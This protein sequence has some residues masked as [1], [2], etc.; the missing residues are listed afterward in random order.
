[1]SLSRPAGKITALLSPNGCGKP[2]RLAQDT[3]VVLHDLN[4]ASRCV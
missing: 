1:M 3:P 2:T 4:Q